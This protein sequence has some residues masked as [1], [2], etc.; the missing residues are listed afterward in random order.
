[1]K[2]KLIHSKLNTILLIVIVV[3]IGYFVILQNDKIQAPV[4]NIENT[5]QDK[6]NI[7]GNKDDLIY[8]STSPFSK[9]HGIL[10]YRGAVKGGYF[11]EGNI[12]INILGSDQKVLKKSNAVAKTDWMTSGPVEFE[13]NIDFGGLAKGPAYLEIHNDNASGLKANDKS[14]LIPIII[15]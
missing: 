5:Q 6:N 3:I 2:D 1:M 12:L 11:F 14:I 10:S 8:F 15:E 7:L 13:G 4:N 9:V